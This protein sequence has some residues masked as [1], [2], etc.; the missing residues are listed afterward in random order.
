MKIEVFGLCVGDSILGTA[1]FVKGF[2]FSPIATTKALGVG[3]VGAG[4]RVLS[5]VGF[6]EVGKVI[7]EEPAFAT[8]FVAGE[9]GQA[10]VF[11]K[12]VRIVGRGAEVIKTRISPRFA[13]VKEI[14]GVKTIV[15]VPSKIE[16]VIDIKFAG[17]VEDISVSLRKQAQ[18]AGKDVTATSGARDFFRA[19]KK[20]VPISKPLPSP[21]A[22]SLERGFFADPFGRARV[23]RLGVL[24]EPA[25]A[26]IVDILSGDVTF[27]RA[28]AQLIL[29]EKTPV[30]KFP[31]GLKVVEAKL[32]VGKVLT[33]SE[34]AKLL[35]FQLKPTGKF[36]PIGFISK[37]P[38]IVLAPGE[39]VVKEATPAVTLIGGRRV[40]IIRAGVKVAKPPTQELLRRLSKQTISQ[41]DLGK[42]SKS[43][44]KET[45]LSVTPSSLAL[46][47]PTFIS[48]LAVAPS[49]ISPLKFI[50]RAISPL[51]SRRVE[52]ISPIS[53]PIAPSVPSKSIFRAFFPSAFVPSPARRERILGVSA[54]SPLAQQQIFPPSK[55]PVSP[56]SFD[57]G[58]KQVPP[59][60]RIPKRIFQRTPS[61][62]AILKAEF[63]FVQP[64]LTL[65]AERTGLVERAF[66]QP[67]LIK[68]L[69][70]II[71][72][73]KKKK[74]KEKING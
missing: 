31:K 50:S 11:V 18:I 74:K 26:K 30:A 57:L 71:V 39:I 56:L 2:F 10:F 69:G 70:P 53:P 27:R 55:P 36:K 45:G 60:V 63:G 4:E 12:A 8:G 35:R 9:A 7:R 41:A 13:P 49:V 72:K 52:A 6:P 61:L 62:G 44:V 66:V 21:K 47:R 23:S 14:K 42:L 68:P 3:L 43:L 25:K 1:Q 20:E 73:S 46:S 54:I 59:K 19:F 37:E 48:P 5:G 34:Q 29:F 16:D 64:R 24:D 17:K 33:P 67:K 15:G 51:P 40:E 32:K 58:F 38:E 22:P 28:K 65:E